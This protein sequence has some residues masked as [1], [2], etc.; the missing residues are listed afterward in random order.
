MGSNMAEAHPVGF[1]WVMEAKARGARVIH[2]D[3]RFT[4]T[5]ALADQHVTVRAGTDIAFLGGV[6]N[7]ILANNLEFREYVQA[8]TNAPFL[9][10]EQYQDTEDLDGLFSG[11]DPHA[12]AYD[13]SSWSYESVVAE[14]ASGTRHKEQSSPYQS[15][16]GG[17]VLEGAAGELAHDPSL[18]HPRCV[19]Q[20]LKRHFARYTPEMVERICGVPRDLFLKVCR[21][22]TENSGRERTAAL[23]YSVGWTQ[24][25]V[26]PQC[27]R[28]GA[29]IQLLLGNIGRP[30]GGVFALRGHASIQGSTDIPTLFNL[31]PGY[32]PMPDATHEDLPGYL[33]EVRGHN[34]KGFWGNADTYLISLLKEYWGNAATP[35]NDFCFDYLPRINGDHGT[36]RTVMDMVDGK[37]FGYFLLGENPAVGSAHGRLQRLGLANL[38]WLVVRDLAMIESATFWKDAPEIETGEI[39]TERCGTE[40]FFMPAASHVEKSGTF[41]NTQRL[42][43]WRD[44]AVEPTGDQRSELWFFYHLGRRLKEKLAGSADERDRP[45]LD[46]AW[47]YA[48]EGDEPSG[49]DVLRHVSGI[50][51]RTGRAVDGYLDLRADGS[52]SCGC[53]IYSGVYADEVNQARRRKSWLEQGPYGGEWGWTWPLNRRVL[54]NRASADPQGRPWSERK[55]LIWWDAEHGEWTGHDVPDFEK[56]KPPGYRPPEGA[57]GPQA[58]HGDDPFIMMSDGKGWL[59]APAGL[60]DGPLPTHYEPHESPMR[61]LLYGQQANPVRKVY[62]R[63]DNP[64][65]PAPPEPHSEVFPYVFTAARLTEHHTAG[66]MSRSLPYLS[67]LQP[68]LFVE[69]SPELASERGLRHLDWGHVITSRTAVEARVLVTDRMAPL[70]VDGRVVHQVWMPYHWGQ[71]GLTTGDVVNDLMGAFLDPNVFIQESKVLTCDIRPGR[72]PRG[73]AL[74]DYVDGYRRRAGIT[75]ETGTRILTTGAGP[76]PVH[77]EPVGPVTPEGQS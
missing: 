67:E 9:V 40:V 62:G 58:L 8:Y 2:V 35:E 39:V 28:A 53:W 11:Y 48:T 77:T 76:R 15:G 49:A 5:S 45:L 10:N 73:P 37:V 68:E 57:E 4:R 70:R 65:N 13:R 54:Y 30:G 6:I 27:I 18:E 42:L 14:S 26:G 64:S 31:L 20:I 19:F 7:Y 12:A 47:D 50:D 74:L 23:V 63:P 34:N 32:L 44:Q 41:T 33:D 55:A 24:H 59:F 17:P 71:I 66:G 46:L 36:Y 72:R 21:A 29:I 61:N 69:V 38:D 3:P 60:A 51:L 43:Q 25:S 56:T 22:W 52:T 75:P 1:Q 16:S